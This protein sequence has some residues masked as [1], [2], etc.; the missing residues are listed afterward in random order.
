MRC[1]I[2][3]DAIRK[4]GEEAKPALKTHLQEAGPAVNYKRTEQVW[5]NYYK[6]LFTL[7]AVASDVKAAKEEANELVKKVCVVIMN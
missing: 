7:K 2:Q 6:T 4:A 5:D 3:L 1:P